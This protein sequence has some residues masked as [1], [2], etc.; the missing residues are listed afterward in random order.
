MIS[1]MQ[2]RLLLETFV[3]YLQLV[4]DM[5]VAD[6][7]FHNLDDDFFDEEVHLLGSVSQRGLIIFISIQG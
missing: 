2:L 7:F 3:H 5:I 4:L 6:F 1:I